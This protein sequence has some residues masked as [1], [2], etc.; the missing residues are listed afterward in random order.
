MRE[1]QLEEIVN[2][3]GGSPTPLTNQELGTIY[4]RDTIPVTWFGR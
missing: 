4:I 1:L 2:V 3:S